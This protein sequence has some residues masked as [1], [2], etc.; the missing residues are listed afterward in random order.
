APMEEVPAVASSSAVQ[1]FDPYLH[2]PPAERREFFATGKRPEP[3]PKAEASPK[4]TVRLV[5]ID[6]PSSPTSADSKDVVNEGSVSYHKAIL[7]C[8]DMQFYIPYNRMLAELR[9]IESDWTGLDV[10]DPDLRVLGLVSEID[11]A[12]E[13][14][15]FLCRASEFKGHEE[16]DHVLACSAH[17]TRG[18]RVK[19]KNVR[20]TDAECRRLNPKLKPE[21][22]KDILAQLWT[23]T[24]DEI[25]VIMSPIKQLYGTFKRKESQV[26]RAPNGFFFFREYVQACLKDYKNP[27]LVGD[28]GS[29]VS[30]LAGNLWHK[31]QDQHP[32][33]TA[34]SQVNSRLHALMNPGYKFCKSPAKMDI[35]R[36]HVSKKRHGSKKRRSTASV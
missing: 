7:I 27:K 18:Y 26:A 9:E 15:Q 13:H 2:L 21:V 14:W 22:L 33:F 32:L 8:R 24:E 17:L 35:V 4:S 11:R 16:F 12:W 34:F 10:N 25:I 1:E 20:Y 36:P 31:I 6:K 19:L 28:F 23:E 30:T 5:K 3:A 29:F